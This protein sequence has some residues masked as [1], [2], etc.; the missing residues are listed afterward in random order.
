[1]SMPITV[2]SL[3]VDIRENQPASAPTSIT[4]CVFEGVIESKMKLVSK[5]VKYLPMRVRAAFSQ[6]VSSER[7][8]GWY[9]KFFNACLFCRF[10]FDVKW[11]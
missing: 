10:Y 4:M 6:C 3:F 7:F 2:A 9:S 5:W 11:N 8:T 1:M